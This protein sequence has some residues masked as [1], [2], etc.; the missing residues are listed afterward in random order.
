[1]KGSIKEGCVTPGSLK[2]ML[3]WG[4]GRVLEPSPGKTLKVKT[5]KMVYS[6]AYLDFKLGINARLC[7]CKK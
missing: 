6:E 7:F 3:V 1:M 4:R 2:Q 5:S